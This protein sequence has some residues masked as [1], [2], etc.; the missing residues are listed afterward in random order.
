M[1][2][3]RSSTRR[4]HRLGPIKQTERAGGPSDDD[5]GLL[6][7]GQIFSV[8]DAFNASARFSVPGRNH[9]KL[10]HFLVGLVPPEIAGQR[11]I[12]EERAL[13]KSMSKDRNV[14]LKLV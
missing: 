10:E 9:L 8:N 5:L 6:G 3:G 2:A 13:R 7:L 1:T 11:T 12:L 4:N 14:P